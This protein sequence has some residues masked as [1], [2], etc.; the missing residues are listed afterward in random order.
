MLLS[1]MENERDRLVIVLAGY[2]DRMSEFFRSNPGLG[3]RIAHHI[4]FPDYTIPELMAIAATI[5][6]SQRYCFS[7]EAIGAF[8]QYLERRMRRPLFAH[9]RSVRN[10]IDR[11]RLR[12]A[13]RLFERG[14]RLSREE[15]MTIEP[16]DILKSSI[17][18]EEPNA[19]GGGSAKESP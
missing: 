17:F 5:V 6:E 15:L 10:A 11:A 2:K 18:A 16:Q 4:D 9:G 12:Q 14:G 8:R 7:R 19:P 1:A 13:N 3:S